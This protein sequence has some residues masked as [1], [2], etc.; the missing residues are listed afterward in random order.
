MTPQVLYNGA[1]GGLGRHLAGALAARQLNGWP[2]HSRL[3]DTAGLAEEL[4]RLAIEPDS[5]L[6]L[7]QSAAIVS[8]R[9]CEQDPERAFDVNVTRT[10][11]TVRSFLE[12]ARNRGHAPSVVFVSSGHVYARPPPGDRLTEAA[13]TNPGS[14]YAATKLEGEERVLDLSRAHEVGLVIARVFG[15]IGPDQPHNYLLPGLIRRAR[16]GDLSAVPGLDYVRDYLDARDVSRVLVSLASTFS[17]V[18]ISEEVDTANVC[19]GEPA[20]IGDLLDLV[21][22][23]VHQSDPDELQRARRAAGPAPGR[24]SDIEWSVG[25][26]SRLFQMIAEPIRAIPI[27]DTVADALAASSG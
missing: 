20:R 19:S 22:R 9:E 14:V 11:A 6:A 4:D 2:V 21:L 25:D 3:G 10:A 26:P 27:A 12:W 1:T 16:A 24:P 15:M 23:I 17:T 8:V 5:N 18:G 7:I 13:P